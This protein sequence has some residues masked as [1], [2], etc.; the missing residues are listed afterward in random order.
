MLLAIHFVLHTQ[1]T[2]MHTDAKVRAEVVAETTEPTTQLQTRMPGL[3][4]SFRPIKS[5][6][7]RWACSK[8]PMIL[9]CQVKSLTPFQ[10]AHVYCMWL[11]NIFSYKS[12]PRS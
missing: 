4:L 3:S 9:P 8:P 5:S 12:F 6:F 10:Y 11:H 7:C 1:I 2:S